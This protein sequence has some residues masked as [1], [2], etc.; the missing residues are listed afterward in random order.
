[1]NRQDIGKRAEELRQLIERANRAYYD[2][3]QPFIS[4]REFDEALAELNHLET[5]YGLE[6]E[7]SP[8]QRVGGSPSDQFPT[9]VHPTPML[10]LDNTYNE[11]ELRSE[12]H[13][14]ELQSRG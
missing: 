11:D 2:E 14:S 7:N 13:T 5:T 3:A 6:T 12:E 8:T 1:M 4:D 9:V 10:S